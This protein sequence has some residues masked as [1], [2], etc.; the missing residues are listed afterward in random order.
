MTSDQLTLLSEPR[1]RRRDPDTS[2]HAAASIT[3]GR[4]EGAILDAFQVCADGMTDDDLVFVLGRDY[5][6][7]TVKTARSRLSKAGLLVPSGEVRRSNR[8]R[9]MIVWKAP[10]R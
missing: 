5:Y 6:P 2:R 3:P 9:D 10:N 4:T 7:P 8:G 1:A